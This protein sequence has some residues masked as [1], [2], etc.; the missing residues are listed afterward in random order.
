LETDIKEK[1]LDLST[2]NEFVYQP[3]EDQFDVTVSSE[4]PGPNSSWMWEFVRSP[5]SGEAG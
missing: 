4:E 2:Y 3:E 5:E 1:I